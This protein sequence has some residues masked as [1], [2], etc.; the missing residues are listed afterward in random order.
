[1]RKNA[2][3]QPALDRC[4]ATENQGGVM[5][6]L[7]FLPLLL[8]ACASSNKTPV[9]TEKS[10]VVSQ[11]SKSSQFALRP[12]RTVQLENG[13][14][15]YF[16]EDQSLPRVSLQ[17][18][19][20]VGLPQEGKG[21]DGLNAITATLLEQGTQKKSATVL[22]D[23]FGQIG[24]DISIAPGGD[25]TFLSADSLAKDR[26]Q[27]LNLFSDVVLNPSFKDSEIRRIKSQFKAQIQKKIDNPSSYADDQFEKFIFGDHPY[28]KDTTGDL[29]TIKKISKSNIIKHYLN[30]YRPNNSTLAVVGSLTPEFEEQVVAAFKS[31]KSRP[32]KSESLPG[33]AGPEGLQVKLYSKPGLKQTQI[34]MG[35]LGVSR[36]TEDYLTLRAANEILGGGMASRLMQRVRDDL[37]LTYGISSSFDFRKDL[38]DF[39]ISTFTKNESV[40]KTLEESIKVY[41][42]FVEAGITD[43][44]LQSAKAQMIAQFPRSLETADRF[45]YNLLILDFYEIPIS[46]L[47]DFLKNVENISAS[48]VNRVIKKYLAADQLK[49]VIYGDDKEISKQVE[50]YKP[51][52]IKVGRP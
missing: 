5:K 18:L 17:L 22:A 16:I 30:W 21:L 36:K 12:L 27:L 47:T 44:E 33:V 35:R 8:T 42:H 19:V 15:I 31:W 50:S 7:I 49:V 51:E 2:Q 9:K 48:D 3:H 38:G 10:S 41:N 37:G 40:G 46:Y 43:K 45:A 28:S 23:E 26:G 25:F 14:K 20:K 52:L 29:S 6:K 24:T 13:L 4:A 34:R 1:L 39:S 11:L 32:L